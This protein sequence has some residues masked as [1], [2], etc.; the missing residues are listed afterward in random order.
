TVPWHRPA[1][2]GSGRHRPTVLADNRS[3]SIAATERASYPVRA[4][5]GPPAHA[6]NA[7]TDT[8]SPR[9]DSAA[10]WRDDWLRRHAAKTR[11]AFPAPRLAGAALRL[12]GACDSLVAAQRTGEGGVTGA[13]APRGARLHVA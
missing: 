7:V 5:A 13:S 2:A 10:V 12:L 9:E 11:A 1:A 4:A 8:G 3:R 6:S